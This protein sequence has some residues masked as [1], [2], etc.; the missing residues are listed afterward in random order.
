[1]SALKTFLILPSVNGRFF[2][3]TYLAETTEEEKKKLELEAYE[4]YEKYEKALKSGG[5]L[6]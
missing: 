2:G 4:M 5:E 1:M 6:K 3:Y